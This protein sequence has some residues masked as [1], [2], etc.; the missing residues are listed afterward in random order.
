MPETLYAGK[1][2]S[3]YSTTG[4]KPVEGAWYSG[5]RYLG[6]QLL[7]PGQDQPGQNV[8]NEVIA[9]TNPNNV[10]YVENLKANQIQAPVNLS[11]P[12]NA[13]T[14]ADTTG[15]QATADAARKTL[16]TTLATQKA[17]ADKKL[18]ELK[19]KEQDILTNKVEPLT[20][21]FRQELEASQ[22]EA[23][24]VNKNFEANQKL[25][26]EL[27]TLL[28]EGNQIIKDQQNVTGLS[29][30][31]NPRVQQTM[32]DINARVGVIQAV[33]NA[34]NSQISQAYT[35]IDRSVDAITK[36]RNDQLSY[37][38]TIL[39]LN[40]ND[41][42]SLDNESKKLAN[43]QI[44][45]LENDMNRANETVDYIKKLLVNPDTALV[46]GQ[47]GVN[48]NDSVETINT[49]MAFVQ[50]SNEVKD[51]SNSMA[52]G[53]YSLITDVSSVPANQITTITDSKGQKYY[54]QK[55]D[56]KKTGGTVTGNTESSFNNDANT[57]SGT[58]TDAGFV[59]VFPQL[60]AKYAPYY[61]LQQIY[62]L[63]LK[64]DFGKKNGTPVENAKKIQEIYDYYKGK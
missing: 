16:D 41:M 40:R 32:S 15:L 26:D 14:Q 38:N 10:A 63:Y 12:S 64:S 5:Q 22:K 46:M 17:E 1:P 8:S 37:Y 9:Q 30:I 25:T 4:G 60:V 48:L 20:T 58:D 45:L 36:D 35:Q 53:G 62:N 57:L 24:Y 19:A 6:G 29:A 2:S 34:R 51:L 49:K 61:S 28:T 42:L 59:G 44:K 33:M 55:I 52:E 18:A 13:S 54:Y 11:L 39:E 27:D 43:E 50:Y 56:T 31:R 47:A 21:P 23:L 3:F 7:A